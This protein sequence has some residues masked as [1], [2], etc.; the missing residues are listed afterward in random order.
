M[1]SEHNRLQEAKKKEMRV[2]QLG[3]IGGKKEIYAD[4]SLFITNGDCALT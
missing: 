1:T 2:L 3:Y 4:I